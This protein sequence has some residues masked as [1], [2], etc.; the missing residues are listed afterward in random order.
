MQAKFE[1]GV[2]FPGGFHLRRYWMIDLLSVAG[3]KDRIN[4]E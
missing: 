3:L 4:V 2:V 1:L